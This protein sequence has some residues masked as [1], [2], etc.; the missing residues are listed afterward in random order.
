MYLVTG[1]EQ[2]ICGGKFYKGDLRDKEFLN[3]VFVQNKIDAVIHFAAFSLVGESME[4]PFKYYNNNVCRT[5][6]LLE[7]MKEHNVQKIVF[8]Y[9]GN[10]WRIRKYTYIGRR[11]YRTY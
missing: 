9:S 11:S 3:K 10:L 6:S 4:E 5:L 7:T 8:I 1:H 2:A